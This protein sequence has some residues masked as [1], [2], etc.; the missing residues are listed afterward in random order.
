MENSKELKSKTVAA[1]LRTWG[2]NDFNK[3][4]NSSKEETPKASFII[5]KAKKS[6]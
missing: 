6:A 1:T 4:K 5:P 3:D 2:K